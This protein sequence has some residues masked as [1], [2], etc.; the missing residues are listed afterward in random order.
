MG[1]RNASVFGLHPRSDAIDGGLEQARARIRRVSPAIDG[2]RPFYWDSAA[3]AD[4]IERKE[5]EV[6]AGV[7]RRHAGIH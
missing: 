4:L 3:I 2:D 7:P 5:L 6:R 1:H